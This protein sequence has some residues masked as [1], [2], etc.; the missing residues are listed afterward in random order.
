MMS[1][2]TVIIVILKRASI[3]VTIAKVKCVVGIALISVH[4]V[5]I[6]VMNVHGMAMSVIGVMQ[7]CV[8]IA[9]I[10]VIAKAVIKCKYHYTKTNKNDFYYYIQ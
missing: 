2:P 8:G 7:D 5:D 4:V 6:C 3:V 9:P 1:I 10:L